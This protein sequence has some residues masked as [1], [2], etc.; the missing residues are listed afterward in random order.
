MEAKTITVQRTKIIPFDFDLAMAIS[1]GEKEG[2]MKS[3]K[4][5]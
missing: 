3:R 1:R 5:S 4:R 2:E